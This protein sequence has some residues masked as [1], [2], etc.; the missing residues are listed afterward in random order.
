MTAIDTNVLE[1]PCL[2]LTDS[3]IYLLVWQ[4]IDVACQRPGWTAEQLCEAGFWRG[5]QDAHLQPLV[6]LFTG[7]IFDETSGWTLKGEYGTVNFSHL[8]RS[9]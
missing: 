6:G 5:Q 8:K 3:N 2:V 1:P 9:N 7:N 4:Q